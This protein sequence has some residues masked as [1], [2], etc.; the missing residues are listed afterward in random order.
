MGPTPQEAEQVPY[1][2]QESEAPEAGP[3]AEDP[4]AEEPE[5]AVVEE[6]PAKEE[7]A[8]EEEPAVVAEAPPPPPWIKIT[9]VDQNGEDV[10]KYVTK[11]PLGMTFEHL[12]GLPVTKVNPGS[13]AEE[14]GIQV[15]WKV[16]SMSRDS[17]ADASSP[18]GLKKLMEETFP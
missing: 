17:G 7:E 16:K 18:E 12:N 3:V 11:R 13:Q 5:P 2:H 6:E 8:I 9:F 1:A 14:L 10:I 15:G 4:P